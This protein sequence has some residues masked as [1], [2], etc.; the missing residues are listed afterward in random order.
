M[1]QIAREAKVKFIDQ[2]SDDE[3]PPAPNHSFIGMMANNMVI[4]TEA[5][6]G[7]KTCMAGIDVSN[8]SF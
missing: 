2:L 3:L 6:G 7:D 4:M 5:L 8:I 1:A